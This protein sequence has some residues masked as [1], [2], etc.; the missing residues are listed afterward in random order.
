MTTFY[1]FQVGDKFLKLNTKNDPWMLRLT[2]KIEY[3]TA[4]DEKRKNKSWLMFIKRKYP[5]VQIKEATLKL[6]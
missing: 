2:S 5:N 6:K 4:W 1:V 3:A